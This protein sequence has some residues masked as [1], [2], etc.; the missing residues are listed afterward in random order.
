MSR[1]DLDTW[2]GLS[3]DEQMSL[4]KLY[5]SVCFNINEDT[6][7][8]DVFATFPTVNFTVCPHTVNGSFPL[9]NNTE[10]IRKCWPP[11]CLSSFALFAAERGLS[12]SLCT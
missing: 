1:F 3:K 9:C 4:Y 11:C 12:V 7:N 6:K 8:T 2:K 5:F 10:Y